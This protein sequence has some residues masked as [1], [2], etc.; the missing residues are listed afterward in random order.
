MEKKKTNHHRY[1]RNAWEIAAPRR[2]SFV[3]MFLVVLRSC[4]RA[5]EI[6]NNAIRC[7]VRPRNC[8]TDLNLLREFGATFKGCAQNYASRRQIRVVIVGREQRNR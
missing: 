8:E 7:K 3:M 2:S 4:L 6:Q 1:K 5:V